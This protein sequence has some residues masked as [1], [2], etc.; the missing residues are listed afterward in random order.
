[1]TSL[2]IKPFETSDAQ[3]CRSLRSKAFE[4]LFLKEIGRDAVRAGIEAYAPEDIILLAENN[5]FFVA[6]A[7]SEIVGF[8]GSKIHDESTIEILFLYVDLNF[9]KK[10]VGSG[11]LHH[12]EEYV[13]K[14]LPN[15]KTIIVDTVIPRYNQKFY[16][17]MGYVKIGESFYNYP[18]GKV[19]AVRLEKKIVYV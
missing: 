8:I 18:S 16:E 6:E 1:M 15:I 5:P 7:Q 13:I 9:L 2:K 19:R 10:G 14:N 4:E 12:F 11:L 3:V 17:K